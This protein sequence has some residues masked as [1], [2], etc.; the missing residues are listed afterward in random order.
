[1]RKQYVKPVALVTGAF[2]GIGLACARALGAN[3]F[4]LVLNDLENDSNRDLTFT[5]QQAFADL[6]AHIEVVLADV[7]DRSAHEAF[8]KTAVKS[9]GRLDCLVNNA[10]IPPSQRGDLLDVSED[11]YDRCMAV[12]T[13][14][15]FFL[16]Q[17]VAR[18]FVS[19]PV[20]MKTHRSII[21][22]TSSN[23]VAVSTLRGEY[24]ISKAAASMST[25]LFALRLAST[26]IGVYEVRPGI[27]ETDMTAPAKRK[28]DDLIAN[29]L[30]P[31]ER[32]GHPDDVASTVL[33]MAEGRLRYTVGQVVTV[34]GGLITP[35]F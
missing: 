10:G 24:C 29:G 9:F 13:K 31:A 2:R 27:I 15:Q 20:L 34:D 17:R 12:N 14:A 8:V 33:C 6:G 1:M 7:S 5:L 35:R 23:A 4:D 25:Q 32:W 11:S 18:Y 26:G 3:G 22:I 30:I 28:Y 21:N 16:T 19:Q